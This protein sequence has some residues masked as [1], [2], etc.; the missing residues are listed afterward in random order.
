MIAGSSRFPGV[1]V[2]PARGI[3]GVH[4]RSRAPEFQH[5]SQLCLSRGR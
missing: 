4:S 1:E 5:P 2:E 3:S